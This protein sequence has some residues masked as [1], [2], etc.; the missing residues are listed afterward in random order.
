MILAD[1]GRRVLIEANERRSSSSREMYNGHY[2]KGEYQMPHT[3]GAT[4]PI[5][6]SA[7]GLHPAAP[8]HGNAST[9]V[10]VEMS[11]ARKE[12]QL[13]DN[14][15]LVAYTGERTG[16]SPKDRYIVRDAETESLVDWGIVNQPIDPATF[17]RITQRVREH[18][19]ERHLFVCDG[20][21][22]ADPAHRL[23]VR[24]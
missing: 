15:A 4:R 3:S 12:S 2:R 18:L 24:V 16:R 10:L 17:E 22:C 9:P 7:F 5:D 8:V 11:L 13:T 1:D 19:R 20:E 14:G 21:A 23:R 6:L